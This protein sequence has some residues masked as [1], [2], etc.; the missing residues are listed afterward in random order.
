MSGSWSVATLA[1]HVGKLRCFP[2]R[3]KAINARKSDDVTFN[4]VRISLVFLVL[5]GC[6]GLGML[7]GLPGF[8]GVGMTGEARRRP[9]ELGGFNP[10]QRFQKLF[11]RNTRQVSVICACGG[12]VLSIT[13]LQYD[14]D[15]RRKA[16]PLPNQANHGFSSIAGTC[17]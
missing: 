14:G 8:G 3:S 11:L 1:T 9:C 15:V 4:A 17:Q 6:Q 2:S 10:R 5:Q 13:W 12:G 7:R 16:V